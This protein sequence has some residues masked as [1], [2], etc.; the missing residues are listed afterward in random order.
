MSLLKIIQITIPDDKIIP[1]VIT[2]FSPEEN[3]L[4]LKIGI[5][6]LMEGRKVVTKLTSDEVYKKIENEFKKDIEKL[7]NQIMIEKTTSAK[8]QEKIGKIY[9][10]QIEQLNIKL[11]NAINQIKN[12]E[13]DMESCVKEEVNKVKEKYKIL[14]DEK[15]KQNQLNREAFEKAEKI[16]NKTMN[17]SSSVIGDN[18]EQI[19]ENLADTFKD[20]NCFKIE[21]K[22][23]QNHKGDFHLFFKDFNVLVDSKNYSTN[24]GKKE[25]QKIESDL[26]TNNNMDIAWLV[27]LKSN[28]CEYNKFP[29]MLKW[30]TTDDGV[31]KFILMINNLLDN[32]EPRNMLRQ[33]WQISDEFYRL[34]NMKKVEY[35]ELEEY[36]EKKLFYKKQINNLQERTYELRRNLNTSLNVIKNMDNDL[37]EML[38]SVSDEIINKKNELL[39]KIKE[40]WNNNIECVNNDNKII[41]TEIWSKFKKEN[42]EYVINNK[43]TAEM[44]KDEITSD[45]V[46]SSNYVE[47]TKK[48]AIEFIGF[49]WKEVHVMEEKQINNLE[50]ENNIIESVNKVKKIKVKKAEYYLDEETDKMIIEKYKND[51]CDII[52]L[53]NEK[54]KTWQ[55]ISLLVH[56]KI[57]KDRSEARG[58]K[59]Y[60]ETE[61]YKNKYK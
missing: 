25:I 3:Y 40:W 59:K 52:S 9:E 11:D 42:K 51:S 23:N 17:K 33:A 13:K 54:I 36:R 26:N 16:I 41:S 5:D 22:A 56:H 29:I 7:D 8:M 18:G 30:V 60:I 47:K 61:E 39:E 6:V 24:V 15:D 50:L 31:V 49:K 19:F 44:F 34:T 32:K 20:F 21:N 43:I 12:Y 10:S 27:S 35:G 2:T 37:L 53:S 4:I 28:I 14:L 38:K 57:I 1:D 55:I 46:K 48:G 58:Y 45:I